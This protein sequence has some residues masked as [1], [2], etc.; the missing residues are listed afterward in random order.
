[1]SGLEEE[2]VV[3]IGQCFPDDYVQSKS[4]AFPRRLVR[5][6]APP[7]S[8]PPRRGLGYEP[9]VGFGQ[10][11]GS[12]PQVGD[13]KG[14][15]T[16]GSNLMSICESVGATIQGGGSPNAALMETLRGAGVPISPSGASVQAGNIILP[17]VRTAVS[18]TIAAVATTSAVLATSAA[19]AAAAV[20]GTT[21]SIGSC[22]GPWGAAIGAVA[23]AVETIVMLFLNSGQNKV[24]FNFGEPTDGSQLLYR[25][26]NQWGQMTLTEGGATG[27][28]CGMSMYDYI[29][30][31]YPP[32][33]TGKAEVANLWQQVVNN[34]QA[35][36]NK[37]SGQHNGVGWLGISQGIHSPSQNTP[38]EFAEA[39]FIYNYNNW[40]PCNSQG[41]G[42]TGGC[43]A[44]S[45]ATV[46]IPC[47]QP[48]QC[49][50]WEGGQ[51]G[52][53]S[54]DEAYLK[55]SQPISPEVLWNWLQPGG[56]SAG[57]G[58]TNAIYNAYYPNMAALGQRNPN[59]DDYYN[60]WAA[61]T[62]P[63]PTIGQNVGLSKQEILQYAE[64]NRPSPMFYAADLYV[65]QQQTGGGA[66]QLFGNCATMSGVAT[67]FGLLAAGGSV[68]NIA[69]E[70]LI[71]QSKLYLLDGQVPQLFQMLVNEYLA[72]AIAEKAT[73]VATPPSQLPKAA[74]PKAPVALPLGPHIPVAAVPVG[75][76]AVQGQAMQAQVPVAAAA[77]P[78]TTTPS[79]GSA[80]LVGGIIAVAG[81]L[82]YS[83]YI[84]QSPITVIQSVF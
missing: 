67:V 42:T 84:K 41:G 24:D 70:L 75:G 61:D 52:N 6:L 80:L 14:Q 53:L 46:F 38:Q 23:A 74:P 29:V 44:G 56:S 4:A 33:A 59:N 45:S 16:Y 27:S 65:A 18:V 26:V 1:M 77:A 58:I 17:A 78:T 72:K 79:L 83:A 73:T 76:Q 82:G 15:I 81:F 50:V 3:G 10:T 71:M 66:N 2:R 25:L 40:G 28:P 43:Q 36:G 34:L 54:D 21:I 11:V 47:S 9:L 48:Y 60:I 63:I 32:S 69:A 57:P 55:L 62:I 8:T 49:V 39:Y 20:A 68:Q 64:A 7:A 30:H 5:E 22:A 51:Q 35:A 37:N 19:A 12:L 31:K 13:L